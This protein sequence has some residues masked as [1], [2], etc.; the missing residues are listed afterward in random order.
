MNHWKRLRKSSELTDRASE[1]SSITR[2]LF[3]ICMFILLMLRSGKEPVARMHICLMTSSTILRIIPSAGDLEITTKLRISLISWK[4]ELSYINC[5]SIKKLWMKK[6]NSWV[7]ALQKNQEKEKGMISSKSW[8]QCSA[9]SL[10]G[11]WLVLWVS[12]T[13]EKREGQEI[14]KMAKIFDVNIEGNW[15]NLYLF[16]MSKIN[17]I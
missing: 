4:A 17:I 11:L 16:R 5:W 1:Y 8:Q 2:P 15:Y 12:F 3:T 6:A 14:E 9:G 7:T 10:A 13:K